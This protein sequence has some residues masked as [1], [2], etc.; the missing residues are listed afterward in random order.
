MTIQDKALFECTTLEEW[1]LLFSEFN[2]SVI[3]EL[4]CCT[5]LTIGR[6]R[7]ELGL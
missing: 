2:N 1:T 7:K 5:R 3:A 4:F 6:K